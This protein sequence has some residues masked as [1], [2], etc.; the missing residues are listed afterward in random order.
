MLTLIDRGINTREL[1]SSNVF[2]YTFEHEEWPAVHTDL[3]KITAPYNGSIFKL[4]E[5]Y[6]NIYT[7]LLTDEEKEAIKE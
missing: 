5:N 2:H 6:R 4:R 1:L 7:D 3:S